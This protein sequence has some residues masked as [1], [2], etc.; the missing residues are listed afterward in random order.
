MSKTARLEQELETVQELLAD[1]RTNVQNERFKLGDIQAALQG[2]AEG[3]NPDEFARGM[4]TA[5]ADVIDRLIHLLGDLE[6]AEELALD[7]LRSE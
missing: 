4:A 6:C 5:Y 7:E 2:I 3:D 1:F